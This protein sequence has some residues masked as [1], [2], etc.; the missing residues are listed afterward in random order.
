MFEMEKSQTRVEST[1]ASDTD[2][3]SP[4]AAETQAP[5]HWQPGYRA[6]FPVLGIGA[7]V[8]VLLS[9]A[10]A[11]AVLVCSDR[12]SS[13]QWTQKL[14]PNVVIGGINAFSN[15]MLVFA[16]GQGIAIACKCVLS[17]ISVAKV[18]L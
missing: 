1:A 16:I 8:G 11:V 12:K 7:L 9:A 2:F 18:I 3:S 15:I 10:A 17:S 4:G 14:A 5:R 6:R 13:S